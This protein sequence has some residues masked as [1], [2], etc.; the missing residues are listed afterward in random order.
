MT[1]SFSE[2]DTYATSCGARNAPSTMDIYLDNIIFFLQKTGGISVYW[3]ELLRGLAASKQRL[4]LIEP[5]GKS[6]NLFYETQGLGDTVTQKSL[7]PVALERYSPISARMERP[8]IVHSSYYRVAHDRNAANVVTVHDF[9]YER[10]R[11]G[12]AK[13]VHHWQKGHAIRNADGIICVS[14]STKADLL[15]YFPNVPEG[16]I[17]VVHHGVSSTYGRMVQDATLY[18][19]LEGVLR[20]KYV[21]YVGDRRGYKNFRVAVES[22]APL[23]SLNLVI[24]GG[25]PLTIEEKQYLDEQLANRYHHVGKVA[26]EALNLLYKSAFALIH[27]SMYEGFGIPVIEA[28]AAGCPVLAYCVSSIPEVCGGACA[29]IPASEPEAFTQG[30]AALENLDYRD[31]LIALGCER[32][33][34]FSWSKTIQQTLDVYRNVYERKFGVRPDS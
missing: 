18:P 28:M 8:A 11:R 5:C 19:D 2:T 31:R 27:P 29:C 25:G 3:S 20:R 21:L 13:C 22:V 24:V 32:S 9:T 23:D 12:V 6:E 17:H 4:H 1:S 10:Y 34:A 16:N 33:A 7:W 14:E 30:L 15:H 26:N